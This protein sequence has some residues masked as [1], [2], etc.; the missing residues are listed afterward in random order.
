MTF[1]MGYALSRHMV[2]LQSE[3]NY[4]TDRAGR[5]EVFDKDPNGY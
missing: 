2:A 3:W 1:N 5:G 4:E